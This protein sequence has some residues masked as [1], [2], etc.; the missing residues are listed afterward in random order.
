[1]HREESLQPIRVLREA[2][3]EILQRRRLAKLFA[4]QNLVIDQI[5]QLLVILSDVLD[6]MPS[7]SRPTR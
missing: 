3:G 7:A 6:A 4:D 2:G 5:E 1:M